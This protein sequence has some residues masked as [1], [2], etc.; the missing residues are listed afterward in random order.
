[1]PQW[2]AS[3]HYVQTAR[4]ARA[5]QLSDE[6]RLRVRSC[7]E[8]HR[9]AL[10]PLTPVEGAAHKCKRGNLVIR[11]QLLRP[12]YAVFLLNCWHRLKMVLERH[13]WTSIWSE[14]FLHAVSE[15]FLRD[16]SEQLIAVLLVR[17][18]PSEVKE[19]LLDRHRSFIEVSRS[20]CWFAS[21][22]VLCREL[23]KP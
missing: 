22:L 18:R 9:H 4:V 13:R 16:I 5:G 15:R 10:A 20:R 8:L 7:V 23:S 12:G 17:C 2:N 19:G 11:F 1:M 6:R 14:T 21:R 3:R